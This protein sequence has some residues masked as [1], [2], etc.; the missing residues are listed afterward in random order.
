MW[1]VIFAKRGYLDCLKSAGPPSTRRTPVVPHHPLRRLPRSLPW[2]KAEGVTIR[3][4][5]DIGL[6]EPFRTPFGMDGYLDDEGPAT[7][8]EVRRQREIHVGVV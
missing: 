4:S 7:A 2:D 5:I 8:H 3:F 6:L 1:S